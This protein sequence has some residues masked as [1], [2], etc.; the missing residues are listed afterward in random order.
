MV[1]IAT[2]ITG[3]AVLG[4]FGI[5]CLFGQRV[6]SLSD[7]LMAASYECQWYNQ[8][9]SFKKSLIILRSAC[10]VP[11]EFG[12]L[13][14]RF[15]HGSFYEVRIVTKSI[16]K[17]NYLLL[18]VITVVYQSFNTLSRAAS[19]RKWRKIVFSIFIT[20]NVWASKLTTDIVGQE[21]CKKEYG[22]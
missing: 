21:S 19:S 3:L 13:N 7:D 9:K 17:N 10:A 15:T 1:V 12:V 18:Q 14:T 20:F 16:L 2:F 5:L 4:Q 11:I 8:S 6:R 22:P